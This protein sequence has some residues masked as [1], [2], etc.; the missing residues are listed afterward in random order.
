MDWKKLV[1]DSLSAMAQNA[2]VIITDNSV[3]IVSNEEKCNATWNDPD[4]C[5]YWGTDCDEE[6]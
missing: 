6:M 1:A 3:K 4:W 2:D 5:E